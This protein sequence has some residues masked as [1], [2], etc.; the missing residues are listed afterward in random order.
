MEPWILNADDRTNIFTGS[1]SGFG[2]GFNNIWRYTPS[3]DLAFAP[4]RV[5]E[6]S[7]SSPKANGFYSLWTKGSFPVSDVNGNIVRS[8][9]C[10]T[11][12]CK[13][14]NDFSTRADYN[15]DIEV[16]AKFR[17]FY[18]VPSAVESFNGGFDD[19]GAIS[20]SDSKWGDDFSSFGPSFETGAFDNQ[21]YVLKKWVGDDYVPSYT[22]N[23]V[24]TYYQ[25]NMRNFRNPDAVKF[26][27]GSTT[28]YAEDSITQTP[29]F[30]QRMNDVYIATITI[31]S[32]TIILLFGK[33]IS[34]T[35]SL[36]YN[37]AERYQSAVAFP[38]V[39]MFVPFVML[40]SASGKKKLTEIEE[41]NQ[42]DDNSE[43][44]LS[45]V[46]GLRAWLS[47]ELPCGSFTF[48]SRLCNANRWREFGTLDT[49]GKPRESVKF[50]EALCYPLVLPFTPTL[51]RSL[52]LNPDRGACA[53]IM[54]YSFVWPF[55]VGYIWITWIITCPVTV[56]VVAT[57]SIIFYSDYSITIKLIEDFPQMVISFYYITQVRYNSSGLGSATVSL[58]VLTR[59]VVVTALAM[60]KEAVKEFKELNAKQQQRLH[61]LYGDLSVGEMLWVTCFQ[62]I[63][64]GIYAWLPPVLMYAVRRRRKT[65]SGV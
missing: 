30:C 26:K 51:Y 42:K 52:R 8:R 63:I 39:G 56:I 21:S 17:Y 34:L 10:D 38:F 6:V 41:R 40:A 33:I 15:Q 4:G 65:Q 22:L 58:L 7:L 23:G 27:P 31:F 24:D 5:G 61:R 48:T 57:W 18:D 50:W 44:V 2:Y 55:V 54:Y 43:S 59:I 25:V 47:V 1:G 32:F 12:S 16:C 9:M 64:M 13:W 62:P 3:G 45:R 19:D 29:I 35:W 60:K 37:P 11:S 14:D 49:A 20:Y 28:E 46:L 36:F 53:A